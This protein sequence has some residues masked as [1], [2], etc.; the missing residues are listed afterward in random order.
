MKRTPFIALL[1][2]ISGSVLA[3]S[4]LPFMRDLAGD[5]EL[6]KPWGISIDSRVLSRAVTKVNADEELKWGI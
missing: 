4:R 2:V 5:H 1:L 3:E 6:P